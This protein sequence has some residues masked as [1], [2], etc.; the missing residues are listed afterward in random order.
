MI[1]FFRR[2]FDSKLGVGFTLGFLALIALAFAGGDISGAGG[3][4]AFSSGSKIATVGDE[5]ITATELDRQLRRV[6]D[7]ARQDNPRLTIKEFLANDGLDR[8]LSIMIDNK[9]ALQWGEDNGIHIGG[10]LIDS[11]IAKD[12]RVQ[13]PDG[14][15]D[16]LLYQRMLTERGM[17]DGDYRQNV[18]EQLMARQLMGSTTIGLK[19]P[20]KIVQRYAAVVTEQRKGA[21]VLLPPAAFAPATRPSDAEVLAWYNGHKADYQLPERR[22]IR[23]ATYTDAVIK[24]LPP[25]TDAEVAARFNANKAKYAATDKRKLSQLILP[26]EAA[27]RQIMADLAGGKTLEASARGK[28]L[29]VAS[30][31]SLTRE[32]YALQSSADG[33]KAVFAAANGKVVGPFK[34]PLGWIVARIDGRETVP[35]KTLD[36]A[37]PELVKELTDLKRQNAIIEFSTRIEDEFSG[38]ASLTDVAKELGLEIVESPALTIDG[39]VFGQPEGTAPAVLASVLPTAFQMDGPGNPQL[40]Q[41]EP[42]KLF[43]VFDVG[44]LTPASPPPLADIRERVSEDARIAKGAKAAEEAAR[45]LKAQIEKGVPVELAVAS[46]GVALPPVDRV[47]MNRQQMQQMGQNVPRPL[48]VL[49]ATP[50]GKVTLM[51]GPRQRGWYVVTVT[52]VTP[53]TIA[54]NDERL[55][56]LSGSLQQAQ[57][58]EFAEQMRTS[59]RGEVGS[60][61]N[62]ENFRKLQGQLAGGN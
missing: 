53:G 52:D 42:G 13:G 51:Q 60:S 59:F 54:E 2:F 10:R 34:A 44:R 37:R 62:E 40:A 31:G 32:A 39:A 50:R 11:E 23:Y 49:F 21:I 15:V 19:M 9:A 33:A 25:P 35:G 27:A 57:S 28:G 7:Q 56:G 29:A 24:D 14:K 18:A 38:G 3:F 41:V 6:L 48:L 8:V 36:Q 5:K 45:R 47:D 30:L 20:R 1:Q 58:G 22:T 55:K 16:R 26:T 12:P 46:L 4:G 61:R 17:T 43:M